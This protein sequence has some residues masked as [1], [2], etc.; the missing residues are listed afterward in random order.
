[1]QSSDETAQTSVSAA[2]IPR[3]TLLLSSKRVSLFPFVSIF[4]CSPI[5]EYYQ[6]P[7]KFDSI[8]VHPDLLGTFAVEYS[9]TGSKHIATKNLSIIYCLLNVAVRTPNYVVAEGK[10]I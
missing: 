3:P 6:K 1:M 2:F 7:V 8:T 4:K 5:N 9:K 10:T